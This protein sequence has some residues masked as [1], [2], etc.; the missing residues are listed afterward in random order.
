MRDYEKLIGMLRTMSEK[1]KALS[2][3][4]G[5]NDDG[6]S[7]LLDGS[8][9]AIEELL[10]QEPHWISVEERL[11]EDVGCYLCRID[12]PNGKWLEVCKYTE[13][14]NF[15]SFYNGEDATVFVTNWMPLPELPKEEQ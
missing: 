12:C 6:M 3:L 13:N 8:A 2:M 7:N 5:W 4:T 1:S 14:K 11:P 10:T 9:D 15:T